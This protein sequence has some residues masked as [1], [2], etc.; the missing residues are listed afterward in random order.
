[1]VLEALPAVS[2][3]RA[4]LPEL[5]SIKGCGKLRKGRG[6]CAAHWFRWRQFGDPLHRKMGEVRDGKRICAGCQVDKPVAEYGR[7][8]HA[9]SG[10]SSNCK[11]CERASTKRWRIEHPDYVSPPESPEAQRARA[12]NY[13][14]ANPD[15]VR[16]IT[17]LRR[18]RRIGATVEPVSPREIFVRDCWICQ[19]CIEPIDPGAPYP[20]PMSA[21]VD[22]RLPLARGGAHSRDNCQAAHLICN[23][24]KH[25]KMEVANGADS[26]G[27]S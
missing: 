21:S 3:K 1:L 6:W 9:H 13:R 23:L 15:K 17:A 25:D 16:A 27:A 10:L 19:I 12:R 18:A 20:D 2:T 14:K 22:H 24:R 26:E 11:A 4:P 5:C 7:R 8:R